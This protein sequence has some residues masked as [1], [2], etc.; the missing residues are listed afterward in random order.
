MSNSN[1]KL[2]EIVQSENNTHSQQHSWVG[3]WREREEKKSFRF[4]FL[5]P[6]SNKPLKVFI[7]RLYCWL[8]WEKFLIFLLV[9]LLLLLLPSKELF[10]KHFLAPFTVFRTHFLIQTHIYNRHIYRASERDVR[11]WIECVK[12]SCSVKWFTQKTTTSDTLRRDR[13]GSEDWGNATRK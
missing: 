11:V 10:E 12:F 7:Q 13:E 6:T 3:E 8:W 5:H 1:W 4:F 9:S 2:N